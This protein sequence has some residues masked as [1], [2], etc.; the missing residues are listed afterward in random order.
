M[1]ESPEATESI[2][3]VVSAKSGEKYEDNTLT[4][5]SEGLFSESR[6]M[7]EDE[8]ENRSQNQVEA[9]MKIDLD[10]LQLSEVLSPQCCTSDRKPT[11]IEQSPMQP[12]NAE[13]NMYSPRQA[14][15]NSSFFSFPASPTHGSGSGRKPPLPSLWRKN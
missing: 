7:I 2:K 13:E 14:D 4:L 9:I 5:T 1:I 6:Q 8:E 3:R 10:R 12:I 15:A 11:G